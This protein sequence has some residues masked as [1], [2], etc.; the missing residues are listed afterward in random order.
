MVIKKPNT[1]TLGLSWPTITKTDS[2][3]FPCIQTTTSVQQ[4]V[5]LKTRLKHFC[6]LKLATHFMHSK[7]LTNKKQKIFSKKQKGFRDDLLYSTP[8]KSEETRE[9]AITQPWPHPIPKFYIFVNGTGPRLGN[10][11]SPRFFTLLRG[12]VRYIVFV[13]RRKSF[14]SCNYKML[15]STYISL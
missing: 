2:R 11:I 8:Q 1:C 4:G 13:Y 3:P 7:K 9:I 12:G 10:G 6:Y 5:S 14:A 15:H